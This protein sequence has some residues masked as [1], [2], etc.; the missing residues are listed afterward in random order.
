MTYSDVI[1]PSR[2]KAEEW[3]PE[4]RGGARGMAAHGDRVSPLGVMRMLWKQTELLV[5]A[6][7]KGIK[8]PRSGRFQMANLREFHLV[9][10]NDNK[11]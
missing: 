4:A 11:K 6:F 1:N 7:C 8:R 9:K 3:V 2:Q 5:S 10:N